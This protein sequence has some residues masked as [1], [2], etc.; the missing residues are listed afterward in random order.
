LSLIIAS[1]SLQSVVALQVEHTPL[2]VLHIHHTKWT[3]H[4]VPDDNDTSA[5]REIF[6]KLYHLEPNH[7]PILVHC[8][9]GIGRTGTYC[10]IHNTLQRILAGD[11][12]AVN[13]A[14]T[15]AAFRT[16]RLR[17]VQTKA[18]YRFCYEAIID[19][20][21]DLVSQQELG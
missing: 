2:S 6:K 10:T 9:A 17:M 16:Q 21:E 7:G 12:S 1:C 14:D 3:D 15:V 8:S 13:I 11:M 4:G 5:V 18:Q 20:L 19:E